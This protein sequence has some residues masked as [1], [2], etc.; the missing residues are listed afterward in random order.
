M[1]HIFLIIVFLVGLAFIGLGFNIFFRKRKFPETEVGKN[2]N[3]K[4][5]G[6]SCAKCDE[7]KKFNSAKRFDK[8]SIDV[9]KLNL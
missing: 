8:I 4:S 5:L 7:W 3:M 6:L 1:L 2:K 9:S